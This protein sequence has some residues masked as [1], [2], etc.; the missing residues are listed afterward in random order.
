LIIGEIITRGKLII[1]SR[2]REFV[3]EQ[4]IKYINLINTRKEAPD[5]DP[6]SMI[7][8]SDLSLN[9]ARLILLTQ[10]PEAAEF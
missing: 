2:W 3:E 1:Q 8:A 9:D 4:R 7:K 5:Y 6:F 10:G